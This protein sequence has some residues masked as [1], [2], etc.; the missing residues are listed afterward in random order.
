MVQRRNKKR[1]RFIF[2]HVK[3]G[4]KRDHR[5]IGKEMDLFHFQDDAPDSLLAF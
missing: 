3:G 2:I 1:I 4:R 5:K